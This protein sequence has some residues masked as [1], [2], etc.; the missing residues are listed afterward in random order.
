MTHV[1]WITVY[2]LGSVKRGNE[3]L[4]LVMEKVGIKRNE[5]GYSSFGGGWYSHQFTDL[6][7]RISANDNGEAKIE[8]QG[9]F[10]SGAVAN[11]FGEFLR[12]AKAVG[13]IDDMRWKLTRVDVAIDIFGLGLKHAFPNP[14]EKNHRWDFAFDYNE[15]RTKS[16]DGKMIFTGYTL[17]RQRWSLTVYNKRVEIEGKDSHKIKQA[18]FDMLARKGEAITRVELRIKSAEALVAVQGALKNPCGEA[19]F[20]QAILK[21]WAKYHRVKTRAGHDEARFKKL[22][23]DFNPKKFER[24]KKEKVVHLHGNHKEIRIRDMVR[25]FIR[26][27]ITQDKTVEDIARIFQEQMDWLNEN[28]ELNQNQTPMAPG[29]KPK[30]D[31]QGRP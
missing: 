26:Y 16:K 21:H 24:S 10:W 1:D 18:Y 27:G 30:A 23:C 28:G 25:D 19:E 4:N 2:G 15:H 13:T 14:T 31:P 20:C 5:K 6:G 7:I 11:P 9:L 3:L 22:F 8:P 29:Q 12:I 17:R